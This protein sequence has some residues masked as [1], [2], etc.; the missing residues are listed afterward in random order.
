MNSY[1]AIRLSPI[2]AQFVT[3]YRVAAGAGVT[4]LKDTEAWGIYM[5]PIDKNIAVRET[6]SWNDN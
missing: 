1:G 6:V 5:N 4:L 2:A 3:L